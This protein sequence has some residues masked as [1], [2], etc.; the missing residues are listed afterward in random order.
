MPPTGQGMIIRQAIS[1]IKVFIL[2]N[3]KN[4]QPHDTGIDSDNGLWGDSYNMTIGGENLPAGIFE[5]GPCDYMGRRDGPERP[6]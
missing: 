2:C 3:E 4:R 5:E 6:E 1:I